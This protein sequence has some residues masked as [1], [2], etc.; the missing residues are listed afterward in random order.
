MEFSP[1]LIILGL[2]VGT[3]QGLT[4]AG[5]GILALPLLMLATPLTAQAA[6]PV[7]LMAVAASATIGAVAGL[8]MGRVRYRAALAISV[9]GWVASPLGIWLAQRTPSAVLALL[10]CAILL[11]TAWTSWRRARAPARDSLAIA[12]GSSEPCPCRLNPTT[13]RLIWSLPCSLALART[14]C[15]V[16]F[17]SGLLGVGGGFVVVPALS[18]HTDLPQGAIVDTSL[19]VIAL[20]ALAGIASSASSLGGGI[21]WAVAWPFLGST[22]AGGWLVRGVA[23]KLPPQRA[24]RGFALLSAATALTLLA[25]TLFN[26]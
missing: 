6:A 20:V 1:V 4:G 26:L 16:G 7:A 14:G 3:V 5:G 9:L 21:A 22:V 8:F 2:L 18:K 10:F 19:L 23:D 12:T 24:A 13:G 15:A 11:N 17:L 25:K